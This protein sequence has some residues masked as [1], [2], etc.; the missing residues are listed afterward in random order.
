MAAALIEYT[1]ERMTCDMIFV[2]RRF[3]DYLYLRKNMS[4]V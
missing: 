2:V 3:D 1:K 4:S